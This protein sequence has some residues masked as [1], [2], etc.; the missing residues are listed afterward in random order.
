[1]IETI[2]TLNA[3]SSSVKFQLFAKQAELPLLAHGE[4]ADIGKKP[5]FSATYDETGAITTGPL[6]QGATHEQAVRQILD[7]V[8]GHESGWRITAVA[9]RIVH[10]GTE[11]TA[12]VRVTS[13]IFHKLKKLCP[14]APLHQ[15]HNLAALGIAERFSACAA[16]RLFRYRLSRP[17]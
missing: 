7:W 4:V 16:D 9:H 1:M 12:P 11:F 10:G 6:P 5:V 8:H 13:A 14:L 15:P 3:G 2:L 17:P